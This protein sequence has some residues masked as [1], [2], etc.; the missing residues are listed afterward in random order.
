M[1]PIRYLTVALAFALVA[2]ISA[3]PPM[4]A[5]AKATTQAPAIEKVQAVQMHQTFILITAKGLVVV[6]VYQAV[7]PAT[8]PANFKVQ[9]LNNKR[10]DPADAQTY[11]GQTAIVP[12]NTVKKLMASAD[13]GAVNRTL[14]DEALVQNFPKPFNAK[15]PT[16]ASALATNTAGSATMNMAIAMTDTTAVT[17]DTTALAYLGRRTAANNRPELA[18]GRYL[19]AKATPANMFVANAAQAIPAPSNLNVMR[20][21]V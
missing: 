14:T 4:I 21:A 9:A 7:S 12:A 8:K 13:T 10:Q 5:N 17:A 15:K 11:K 18:A 2:L 1:R 19:G 20:N 16:I 3:S 6:Q